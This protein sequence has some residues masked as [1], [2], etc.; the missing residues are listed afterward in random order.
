LGDLPRRA[1]YALAL[2]A[3]IDFILLE[4]V[5]AAIMVRRGFLIWPPATPESRE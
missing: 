2:V 1:R 4:L 3:Q 5:A